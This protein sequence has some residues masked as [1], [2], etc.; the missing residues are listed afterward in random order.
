MYA[1]KDIATLAPHLSRH[2]KGIR[3]E[4]RFWLEERWKR[5]RGNDRVPGHEELH[6]LRGSTKSRKE[7]VRPRAGKDREVELKILNT[8]IETNLANGLIQGSSPAAAQILFMK[9]NDGRL[10]LLCEQPGSQ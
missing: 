2:P 9:K 1:A 6:K 4:E 3:E 8:Y 10:R 5:V 7:R